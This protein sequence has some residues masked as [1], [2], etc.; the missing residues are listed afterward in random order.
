MPF[1]M[2]TAAVRALKGAPLSILTVIA[3]NPG[4]VSQEFLERNTGYTDKPVSQALAWLRE[5]QIITKSSNGWRL[6]E[7]FQLPLPIQPDET[8]RKNSDSIN[9]DSESDSLT[10]ESSLKSR[11]NSD[12]PETP[13]GDS[14]TPHD[15]DETRRELAALGISINERTRPLLELTP[16]DVQRG[17]AAARDHGQARNT[18][19][20]VICLLNILAN[21]QS[22]PSRLRSRLGGSAYSSWNDE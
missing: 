18:S 1:Q 19:Y 9:N 20:L 22:G 3:L 15:P 5:N 16:N 13:P 21:K 8:S 2:T 12:S 6:A 14:E 11:K 7:G 17:Y 4:G 10:P